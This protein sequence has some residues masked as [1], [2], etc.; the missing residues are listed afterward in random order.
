MNRGRLIVAGVL[1]AMAVSTSEA[2]AQAPAGDAVTG[3]GTARFISGGLEGFTTPFRVDLRGGPSGENPTGA[4]TLLLTFTDPTCFVIRTTPVEEPPTATVNLLNPVT[5]QR[6]VAQFGAAAGGQFIAVSSADGPDDC[7]L[8]SPATVAQVIDGEFSIVDVPPLPTTPA[9]CK[10]G[11][12][13][14]YGD[15]FRNQGQCVAFVQR[16]STPQPATTGDGW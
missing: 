4:L 9:D 1:L 8:G 13:R 2:S 3:S 5:G 10:N 15:T 6:V 11:G 14:N 12:W 7:T 16:G